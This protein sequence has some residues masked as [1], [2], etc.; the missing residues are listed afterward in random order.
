[1]TNPTSV[2]VVSPHF[3]P[4]ARKP[5]IYDVM[6]HLRHWHAARNLTMPHITLTYPTTSDLYNMEA[7]LLMETLPSHKPLA[8]G[9]HDFTMMGI[10]VRIATKE[11][12]HEEK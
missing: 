2:P 3:N 5:T 12:R 11:K 1:M 4:P 8:L 6:L 7:R 9:V 10:D